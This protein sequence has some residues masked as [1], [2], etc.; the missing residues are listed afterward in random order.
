MSAAT[1]VWLALSVETV[2][3]QPA[4][5]VAAAVSLVVVLMAVLAALVLSSSSAINK[6]RHE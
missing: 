3:L 1:V 5:A 2:Y 6:V 4:V